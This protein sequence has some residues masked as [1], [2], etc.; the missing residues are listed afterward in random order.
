ML[1]RMLVCLS[2]PTLLRNP[3][4]VYECDDDEAVRLIRA[5]YAEAAGVIAA[6]VA[7]KPRAPGRRGRMSARNSASS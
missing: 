3:G 7:D 1:V 4:D 5:G 6:E 2:G